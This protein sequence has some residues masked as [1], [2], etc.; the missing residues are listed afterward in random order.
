MNYLLLKIFTLSMIL[1]HFGISCR[2]KIE[3]KADIIP[4][5]VCISWRNGLYYICLLLFFLKLRSVLSSA[6]PARIF[7]VDS[8]S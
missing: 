3:K 8:L 6:D 7:A 1:I 5:S 4:F 2:I